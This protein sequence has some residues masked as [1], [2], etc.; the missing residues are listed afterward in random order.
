[1]NL[2]VY[3]FKVNVFWVYWKVTWS[4]FLATLKFESLAI[5][6]KGISEICLFVFS[7]V[8]RLSGLVK[9]LNCWFLF[10]LNWSVK[11]KYINLYWPRNLKLKLSYI[12]GNG[13]RVSEDWRL[14]SLSWVPSLFLTSFFGMDTLKNDYTSDVTEIRYGKWN[15]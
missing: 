10:I 8:F 13:Q 14:N 5:Q 3:S 9:L 15:V 2:K 4:I 6:S 7:F 11:K 1:M 12:Q